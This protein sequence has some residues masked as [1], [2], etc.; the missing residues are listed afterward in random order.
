[1][2]AVIIEFV[3]N[4]CVPGPG[5]RGVLSPG[6][7]PSRGWL[8]GLLGGEDGSR[9]AGGATWGGWGVPRTVKREKYSDTLQNGTAFGLM[10]RPPKNPADK[11]KGK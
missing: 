10:Q 7:G 8:V 6:K 3:C 11:A 2:T 5:G 4:V 1:M 9:A